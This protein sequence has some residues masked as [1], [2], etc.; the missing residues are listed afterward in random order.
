MHRIWTGPAFLTGAGPAQG[1][2]PSSFLQCEVL[3]E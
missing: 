3:Y 1:W 2:S